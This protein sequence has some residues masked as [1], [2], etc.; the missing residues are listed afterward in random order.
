MH[1]A[2]YRAIATQEATSDI[3]DVSRVQLRR[4]HAQGVFVPSYA[5]PKP[6]ARSGH[7]YAFEDLLALR[8]RAN[9]PPA[10]D[11]AEPTRIQRW[12]LDRKPDD[13]RDATPAVVDGRVD[14]DPDA[15]VQPSATL[16]VGP[17]LEDLRQ[18]LARR[19]AR[20]PE[21]IGRITSNPNIL[22]G[23][24]A[25]AGTRIPTYIIWEWH[26]DGY[27]ADYILEQDPRLQIEDVGAAIAFEAAARR[28]GAA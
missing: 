16:P 15:V 14:F 8:L 27:D 3:G 7:Y 4:W 23:K 13:W 6:N 21:D 25:I 17:V 2:D 11:D 24:P 9:L 10:I 26:E 1:R 5:A 12:L 22:F 18:E 20:S 28:D 19:R